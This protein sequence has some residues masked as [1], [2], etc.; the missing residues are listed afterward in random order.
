MVLN[1]VRPRRVRHGVL[2]G[3]EGEVVAHG[4]AVGGAAAEV[5]TAIL[6]EPVALGAGEYEAGGVQDSGEGLVLDEAAGEGDVCGGGCEVG[7]V[8][9]SVSVYT[10]I[11]VVVGIVGVGW[12]VVG[13]SI[14][15]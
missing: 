12:F 9:G 2:D 5:R 3:V 6:D 11:E 7:V 8:W 10:L 4:L 1:H 13:R 14:R 15:H